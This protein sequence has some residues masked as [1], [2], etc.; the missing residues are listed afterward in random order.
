MINCDF[1][2]IDHYLHL[3][4]KHTLLSKEKILSKCRVNTLVDG[5]HLVI[6]LAFNNQN[7]KRT[8]IETYFG[9]THAAIFHVNKKYYK[10][11]YFKQLVDNFKT[12]YN[13]Q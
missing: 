4:S 13:V 7:I 5:R 9:L 2:K 1:R 6:Y 8:S 11:L 3:V 10:K 12:K